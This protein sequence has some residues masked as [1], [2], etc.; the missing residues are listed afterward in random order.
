MAAIDECARVVGRVKLAKYSVSERTKAAVIIGSLSKAASAN[1]RWFA[2]HNGVENVLSVIEAANHHDGEDGLAIAKLR[3]AAARAMQHLA[4]DRKAR[5]ILLRT[6]GA[7][8]SIAVL[9][10]EESAAPAEATPQEDETKEPTLDER[11]DGDGTAPGADDGAHV[12][13]KTRAAAANTLKQLGRLDEL[14]VAINRADAIPKLISCLSHVCT[15]KVRAAAAGAIWSVSQHPTNRAEIGA[16]RCAVSALVDMLYDD[17]APC[18][19]N[20]AGALGN[21]AHDAMCRRRMLDEDAVPALVAML[22][23]DAGNSLESR[24][25]AMVCLNLLDRHRE[26]CLA[27]V[28]G[29]VWDALVGRE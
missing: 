6:P 17:D 27:V 4:R 19:E 7:I 2:E 22:G 18:R 29:R 14:R 13:A 21:L 12:A 11:K 5:R 8:K 1:R 24:D 26:G 20:A 23:D 9:L 28:C 15:S 10:L 16:S 3:A 25:N